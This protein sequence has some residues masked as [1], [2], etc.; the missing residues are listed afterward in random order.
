[1][2]TNANNNDGSNSDS[3][4]D[5]NDEG[6]GPSSGTPVKQKTPVKKK[7]Q[8]AKQ[9]PGRVTKRGAPGDS[10]NKCTCKHSS[11]W[12]HYQE[13]LADASTV[14]IISIKFAKTIERYFKK[15]NNE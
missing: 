14:D 1:M 4:S 6:A 7:P 10:P 8:P 15:K 13:M 2:D 5:G 11:L 3:S 12:N 9:K